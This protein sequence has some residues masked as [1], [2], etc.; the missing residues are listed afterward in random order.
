LD[1]TSLMLSMLFGAF[2]TGFLMY[3]KKAGQL[4]PILV[5]LALMV[6]P[7]F[8]PNVGV[9]LIVCLI[10]TAVPFLLRGESS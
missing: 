4:V 6:C 1:T 10:L 2:G 5:G 3:G 7:Y 9:M 8:L